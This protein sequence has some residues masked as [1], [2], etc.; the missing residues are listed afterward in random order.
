MPADRLLHPRLGHSEKV[1]GLTDFEFRVWVQYQLSADDYGVMR[2]SAV[3]LQADNDALHAKKPAVV[4]RALDRL[5]AIELLSAFDHQGRHYVFQYD[6]QDWQHVGYPRATVNPPIPSEQFDKC[7]PKTQQLFARHPSNHSS[8]IPETFAEDLPP[9]RARE[10]ATANGKRQTA[11][12]TAVPNARSKRPIFTGQRLTVFDW[13]LD[14][15]ARMLEPHT[16]DFDLHEWFFEL[17][18]KCVETG[19]IPPLRDGGEWLKAVTLREAQRRGLPLRVAVTPQAGK[20]TTR[21]ASALANI[22]ATEGRH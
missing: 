15:L 21:L 8:T 3:T 6:W 20:Q 22:A 1:S 14:D 9:S 18:R 11:M 12:A 2:A 7:S 13:M 19:E 17:D 10:T 5:V 16:E 4:Q